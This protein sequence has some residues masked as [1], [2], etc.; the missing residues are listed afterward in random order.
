MQTFRLDL[1]QSSWLS[2]LPFL[3]MA[4]GTNAS[5]QIADRLINSK[6]MTPTRT[7]KL[8]QTIGNLGPGICLMYLA[9]AP[10]KV[11]VSLPWT[12]SPLLLSSICSMNGM[13]V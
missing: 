5:G 2:I 11:S 7:R 8:L 13:F 6:T 10:Q 1:K 3:M 4:I 12:A 9:L